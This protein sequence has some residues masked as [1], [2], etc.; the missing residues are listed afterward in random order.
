MAIFCCLT[1]GALALAQTENTG[2]NGSFGVTVTN[3]TSGVYDMSDFPGLQTM[4]YEVRDRNTNLL[5]RAYYDISFVQD[6]AG[7]VAGAGTNWVQFG[8]RSP[9]GWISPYPYQAL[10]QVKGSI[11]STATKSR[12]NFSASA[13][14]SAHLGQS[15]QIIMKVATMYQDQVVIDRVGKVL[16]G[17]TLTKAS[18]NFETISQKKPWGPVPLTTTYFGDGSWNV[19]LN[20]T[21][22]ANRIT[23]DAKVTV[24]QTER[25]FP[26]TVNGSYKP[27]TQQSRLVLTGKDLGKGSSLQVF[28][29]GTNI[30]SLKGKL[31]GQF[32]K[33]SF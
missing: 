13:S 11:S 5:A 26:F 22:T 18:A 33:E 20:L 1:P 28:L 2:P 21:T 19:A 29:T 12:F 31:T 6:G 24:N 15:N 30:T 10:Y 16:N 4:N 32:V 7:K 3:V 25:V 23:G 17:K 8:F 14:G 9:A 27:A